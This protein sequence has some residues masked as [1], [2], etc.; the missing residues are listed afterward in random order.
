MEFSKK[1]IGSPSDSI[2]HLFND[3][4]HY[5]DRPGNQ[6]GFYAYWDRRAVS[7]PFCNSSK[8][9]TKTAQNEKDVVTLS[10][11]ARCAQ[12]EIHIDEK[13][14]QDS[15]QAAIEAVPYL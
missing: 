1:Q 13:H 14:L 15:V 8:E 4:Q 2:R 3:G 5:L 12:N 10:F 9:C 7:K 11:F 6:Q